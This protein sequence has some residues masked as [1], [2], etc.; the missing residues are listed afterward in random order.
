MAR[1]PSQGGHPDEDGSPRRARTMSSPDRAEERQAHQLCFSR[2]FGALGTMTLCHAGRTGLGGKVTLEV[3]VPLGA[4]ARQGGVTAFL[5]HSE[6][7]LPVGPGNPFPIWAL[8]KPYPPTEA[9]RGPAYLS[10]SLGVPLGL[11]TGGSGSLPRRER[12]MNRQAFMGCG[13]AP[14][15][16]HKDCPCALP[17][18]SQTGV[19]TAPPCPALREIR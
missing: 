9:S 18:R 5:P 10:D 2:P 6:R 14:R 4:Q 16:S 13:G 11:G 7:S 19:T 1:Y 17:S 3:A 15:A 8:I 12:T